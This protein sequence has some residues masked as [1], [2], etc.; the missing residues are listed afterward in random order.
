M[1]VVVTSHAEHDIRLVRV[2][3]DLEALARCRFDQRVLHRAD[4]LPLAGG[5][6]DARAV[7]AVNGAA[8]LLFGVLPGGLMAACADAIR[9]ALAT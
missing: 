3:G 6:L 8:V 2:D 5:A 4:D 9:L 7:L 1:L